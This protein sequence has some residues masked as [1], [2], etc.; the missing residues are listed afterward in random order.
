VNKDKKFEV[1]KLKKMTQ[2]NPNSMSH[3]QREEL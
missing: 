2:K 1:N 3:F